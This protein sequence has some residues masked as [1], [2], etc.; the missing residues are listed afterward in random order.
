MRPRW[1]EVRL[2]HLVARVHIEEQAADE[3]RR[4]DSSHPRNLLI[5][6]E[7]LDL[8]I[9][10]VPFGVEAR[11]VAVTNEGDLVLFA[12]L[13]EI[14]GAHHIRHVRLHFVHKLALLYHK[15]PIVLGKD[16]RRALGGAHALVGVDADNE[17]IA[18]RERPGLEE[19]VHVAVVHQVEDAVDPGDHRPLQKANDGVARRCGLPALLQPAHA[20]AVAIAGVLLQDLLRLLRGE[21]L[22]RGKPRD[23]RGPRA[24]RSGPGPLQKLPLL[25]ED[26]FDAV[27][28]RGEPE[29]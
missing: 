26:R 25:R 1:T 9:H 3:F 7:G 17:P 12:H 11:V 8:C 19:H 28:Q 22:H 14:V 16:R 21:H 18:L 24:P 23:R 6:L 15:D 27:L 13:T 10:V 2:R 4:R 29:L 20:R 5:H